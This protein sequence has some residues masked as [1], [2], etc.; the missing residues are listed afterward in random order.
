MYQNKKDNDTQL[1]QY[2]TTQQNTSHTRNTKPYNCSYL[3]IIQF[4][5]LLIHKSLKAINLQRNKNQT[6]LN[7]IN[8]HSDPQSCL[9]VNFTPIQVTSPEND[10]DTV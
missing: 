4:Q 3:V 2:L 10:T 5:S 8:A 6:I 7:K 1:A 9:R